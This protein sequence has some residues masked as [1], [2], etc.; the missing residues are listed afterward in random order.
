[1]AKKRKRRL[2]GRRFTRAHAD[3]KVSTITRN[4]E[5]TYNLPR[6]SVQIVG[7][8]RKRIRGDAKVSRVRKIWAQ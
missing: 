8:K 3:G 4:I 1:M 5:K 6:G 7:P 2:K